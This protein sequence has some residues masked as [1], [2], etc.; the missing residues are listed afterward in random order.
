MGKIH[1]LI[2]VE[3]DVRGTA[4]KIIAET[5]NT[6]G[7]KHQLF[8]T[9]SKLYEPLKDGDSDRPETPD[10]TAQPITTIGDK[11]KYFEK[12]MIRLFDI[13]LQKED[14]NTKAKQDIIIYKDNEEI[15]LAENVPVTALVQLENV[16]E[17]LRKQVYDVIP[18]LDPTKK[19]L[20][21][22]AAGDGRFLT[23]TTTRI[24]TKKI[25]K[26]ITLHPGTDKHPPQVQLVT[27]DVA[28]GMWKI[29]SYSGM[30]SPAE[31]S[32]LISRVDLVIE[33][34]KK[35]RARANNGDV[36]PMKIG[37]RLFQYI[38]EGK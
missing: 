15:K 27:E 25:A 8:S 3:K 16:F 24:S 18:T 13:I 22:K 9:S 38:N 5:N 17:D 2:A 1:E 31:K 6:F 10:E 26:P 12:H 23:D 28:T 21:D 4:S 29:T 36:T 11:L 30:L 37:S 7:K 14:A 19:W 35:A 33:A 34:V 20:D 32:D